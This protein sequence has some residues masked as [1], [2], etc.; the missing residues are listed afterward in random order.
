MGDLLL[1][2]FKEYNQLAV[3][4]SLTL[5][6]VI[7]IFG[8]IPS[9]F[10]TAANLEFFGF[11]NGILLSFTGEVM[12]A[13]AAFYLYRKG[14]RSVSREKLEKYPKLQKL[15]SAKGKEAFA[16]IIALR[17]MPFVPSGFVTFFAAIGSVKAVTFLLANAIGKLPSVLLEAYS[18][19]QVLNWTWQG[20]VVLLVFSIILL[21]FIM[22]KMKK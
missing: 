14:F 17:L 15:L 20:K 9:A 19:Y 22:K 6:V 7:S 10:L 11:S 16:L 13:G 1:E 2:W 5:N 21:I 8:I 18:I 12:G 3:I 4:L